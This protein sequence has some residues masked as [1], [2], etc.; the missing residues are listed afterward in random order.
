MTGNPRERSKAI[1]R[2]VADIEHTIGAAQAAEIFEKCGAKC[3]GATVL[4][5]ARRLYESSPDLQAFI[6]SMN[7]HHIGGGHL[8]YEEDRVLVSYAKCCCGAASHCDEPISLSY[9]H[10]SVGWLKAL[11]RYSLGREV[12][13]RI[14]G[15]IIH[16]APECSF[17]VTIP[18]GVAPGLPSNRE[19]PEE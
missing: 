19:T 8:R 1:S 4:R 16:G 11:F 12:A 2:L 10:C 5:K 9:C 6:D 3:I 18:M 13:V 14:L 17:E 7:E 15:S